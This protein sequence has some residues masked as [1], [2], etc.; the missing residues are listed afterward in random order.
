MSILLINLITVLWLVFSSAILLVK[1][2]TNCL[3][4]SPEKFSPVE[5]SFFMKLSSLMLLPNLFL[6]YL[7]W[8]P[9]QAH[10]LCHPMTQL[11][12]FNPILIL[13]FLRILLLL[14]WPSPLISRSALL[15][16]PPPPNLYQTHFQ[17]RGHHLL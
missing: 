10:Y 6:L 11:L 17:R 14:L 12:L 16:L 15:L 1:K 2:L 13:P 3:I 5:M 9:L 7:R 8:I 4:Y